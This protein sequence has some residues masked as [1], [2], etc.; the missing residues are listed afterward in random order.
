MRLSPRALCR[1]ARPAWRESFSLDGRDVA[2]WFPGHMAK[3][4][5]KMQSSLKL[6][7]CIVEVHDARISFGV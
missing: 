4:L 6:V 5:K 2:R 1:A 7:D 3:G